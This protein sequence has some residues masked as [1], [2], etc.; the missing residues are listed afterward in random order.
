MVT[1]AEAAAVTPVCNAMPSAVVGATRTPPAA[2]YAAVSFFNISSE[3][4]KFA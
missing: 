1:A 3:I 2:P 4:S